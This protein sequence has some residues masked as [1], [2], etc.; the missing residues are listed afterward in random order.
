MRENHAICENHVTDKHWRFGVLACWQGPCFSGPVLFYRSRVPLARIAPCARV[1]PVRLLVTI[2]LMRDRVCFGFTR[3]WRV[4]LCV[5]F[6]GVC[7]RRTG[8]LPIGV[9]VQI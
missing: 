3:L 8:P 2:G 9:C 6:C 7:H 1:R 4:S 5:F